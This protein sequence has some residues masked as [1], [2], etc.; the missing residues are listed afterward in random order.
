MTDTPTDEEAVESTY[1]DPTAEVFEREAAIAAA[2][3]A[4]AASDYVDPTADVFADQS[5]DSTDASP[6]SSPGS[7]SIAA[8]QAWVADNPDQADEVLAAEQARGDA[9]RKSL[10]SWLESQIA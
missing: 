5:V 4:E 7:Y 8:I 10:V 6:A 3:D 9:A 1:V 2:A